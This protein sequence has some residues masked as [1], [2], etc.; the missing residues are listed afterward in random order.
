MQYVQMDDEK[1]DLL[2]TPEAWS[3]LLTFVFPAACFRTGKKNQAKP[4]PEC[5]QASPAGSQAA[6]RPPLNVCSYLLEPLGPYS[7]LLR[8]AS[9]RRLL[10]LAPAPSPNSCEK[11]PLNTSDHQNGSSVKEFHVM[12]MKLCKMRLLHGFKTF[13]HQIWSCFSLQMLVLGANLCYITD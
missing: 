10:L 4:S 8:A 7:L 12:M 1:F 13:L 6:V 2:P 11:D 5:F 9:F 3:A